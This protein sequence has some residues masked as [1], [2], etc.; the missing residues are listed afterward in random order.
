MVN[1]VRI[2]FM[3]SII[4]TYLDFTKACELIANSL[5][6][7]HVC[8]CLHLVGCRILMPRGT[9]NEKSFDKCTTLLRIYEL[10]FSISDYNINKLQYA[11]F[12]DSSLSLS[13]DGSRLKLAIN[14]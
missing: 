12:Y 7:F 3:V 4:F 9:E 2:R 5:M 14:H 10:S 11:K 6:Y 1:S 13:L 8:I